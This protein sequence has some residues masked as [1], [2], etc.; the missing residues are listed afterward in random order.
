L[1]GQTVQVFADGAIE[2]QYEVSSGAITLG[3]ASN[4]GVVG[5]P[6]TMLY[7]S[8]RLDASQ[9]LGNLQGTVRRISEVVVRI[10]N[11][12]IFEYSADGSTWFPARLERW[13]DDYGDTPQFMDEDVRLSWPGRHDYLGYVY[14][15]QASALP[16][17]IKGITIKYEVTGR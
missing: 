10:E 14:I 16:L 11:S 12:G 17:R 8:M 13:G 7:Q 4:C 6:Y 2:G 3:R 9:Q 5:L 15:R 1:E